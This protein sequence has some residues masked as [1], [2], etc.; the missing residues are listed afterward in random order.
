MGAQGLRIAVVGATGQVGGVMRR[1]LDERD[2]PVASIRYFASARSA[3]R[4]LPWRGAEVEVEDVATA[5]L[6]ASTSLCSPP[7]AARHGSRRRGSRR[8]VRS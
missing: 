1:M 3:G 2:F 5:D 7:V 8:R 4:V 6:A